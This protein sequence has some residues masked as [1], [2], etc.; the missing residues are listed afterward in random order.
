MHVSYRVIRV[1]NNTESS[2]LTK[3]LFTNSNIIKFC[4]IALIATTMIL[5][6]NSFIVAKS[7][8]AF[9]M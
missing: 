6:T 3:L 9:K 8:K 4:K 2:K 7:T 5:W 1:T